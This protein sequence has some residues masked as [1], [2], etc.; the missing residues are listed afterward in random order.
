MWYRRLRPP[1]DCP[2]CGAPFSSC[3]TYHT[4]QQ[5]TTTVSIPRSLRVQ[6]LANKQAAAAREPVAVTSPPFTTATYERAK[7][8]PRVLARR[9][10][11]D[12]KL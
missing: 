10:Q 2:I 4:G 6:L 8:N 12:K 5:L 11:K 7:H 3:T 9:R 1:S